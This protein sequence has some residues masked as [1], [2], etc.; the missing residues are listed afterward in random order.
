M[1][2]REVRWINHTQNIKSIFDCFTSRLIYINQGKCKGKASINQKKQNWSNWID[3]GLRFGHFIG[4]FCI[5]VFQGWI[6]LFLGRSGLRLDGFELVELLF[7]NNLFNSDWDWS[8]FIFEIKSQLSKK[9]IQTC[10]DLTWK[11]CINIGF[12]ISS[13]CF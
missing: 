7:S 9:P 5:H 2:Y 4:S 1:D 11:W 3:F 13:L 6:V 8:S 10:I 12:R